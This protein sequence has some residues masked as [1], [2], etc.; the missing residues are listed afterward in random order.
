MS[1]IELH[2]DMCGRT[3]MKYKCQ[4]HTH[5]F[6]SRQ[7][8]SD[9]SSKSKNPEHYKE[10]KNLE[11]ISRAMSNTNRRINCIR[12]T[13][14]TKEKIRQSR[15]ARRKEHGGY[16]KL[17]GRHV[18]RIVAEE[19]LGRPLQ[20]GE[21]VHHIDNN[22]HNNSKEN[23]MIFSSQAEHVKWHAAHKRR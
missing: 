23:L 12:M 20:K 14:T 19:I 17:Y 2:C 22:P 8:A 9:F 6:C 1:K 13:D 16:Y 11:P 10:A 18:H 21:V 15:I 4:C 7:C 3:F 5:N